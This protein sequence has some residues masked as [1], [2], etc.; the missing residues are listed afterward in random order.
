MNIYFAASI[1]ASREKVDDY[2]KVIRHLS[3]HGN[4]L[5]EHIGDKNKIPLEDQGLNEKQIFNRDLNFL[6]RSDVVVA[7]VSIPSLGT[8]W[9]IA[10]AEELMK[11][12]LCLYHV[13]EGKRLSAMIKGNPNIT[14]M[15]YSTI[16][17]ACAHI[18]NFFNNLK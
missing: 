3:A 16:K 4:V 18:D 11:T 17:E 14:L 9:E 6:L 7:D 2:A 13:Q 1:R 15:E 12:I 8:G 10:K 5:T